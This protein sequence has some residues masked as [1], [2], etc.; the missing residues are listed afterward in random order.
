MHVKEDEKE[1][2]EEKE[3]EGKE[4][5]LVLAFFTRSLRVI[6]CFRCFLCMSLPHTHT[7]FPPHDKTSM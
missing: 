6:S 7:S 1:K 5:N 2:E 3:K 4:E